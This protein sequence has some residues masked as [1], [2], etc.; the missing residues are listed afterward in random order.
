MS[1]K[2]NDQ[3]GKLSDNGCQ[4]NFIRELKNDVNYVQSTAT[5]FDEK[6]LQYSRA[7][8]YRT[9]LYRSL[10]AGPPKQC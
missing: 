8:L 2:Y 6:N 10:S 4:S 9:R 1:T 7:L 3:L 5:V